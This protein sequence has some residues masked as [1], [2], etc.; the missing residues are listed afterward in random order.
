MKRRLSYP[1]LTMLLV[2]LWLAFNE[3]LWIGHILLGT[4]A[5]VAA[6]IAFAV[7]ERPAQQRRP[8]GL[9]RRSSAAASL[10]WVVLVDMIRSNF[11]VGRIVLNVARPHET[12]ALLEIP[13]ELRDPIGLA[14]LACIVTATPGTAWARYD[15][16][17]GVLT[18]HILD[19]LD[20]SAWVR[21]I[22]GRYEAR[23]LEMF[24]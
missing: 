4:A 9:V 8:P 10:A 12:A 14:V 1:V 21:I 13:L 19:L 7:L 16:R 5:A 18:L 20:E 23:L 2:G 6:T 3:T 24:E 17:R 15:D 11:D 22:K